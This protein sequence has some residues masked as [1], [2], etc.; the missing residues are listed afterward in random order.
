MTRTTYS[1]WLPNP[2]AM[3]TAYAL[4]S[5]KHTAL[6]SFWTLIAIAIVAAVLALRVAV[7]IPFAGVVSLV[8]V[9]HQGSH[10][11]TRDSLGALFFPVVCAAA[12]GIA[13]T[14]SRLEWVGVLV[15]ALAP[16]LLLFTLIEKSFRTA[17]I[18]RIAGRSLAG[19]ASV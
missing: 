6:L 5:R 8:L 12:E 17:P 9:T 15:L 18:D 16:T 11:H 2:V 3:A 19:S 7:L 10:P 4:D 13:A 1:A 14:V